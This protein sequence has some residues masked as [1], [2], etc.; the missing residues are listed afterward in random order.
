MVIVGLMRVLIGPCGIETLNH[1][2]IKR[3]PKVLIGPCGIETS[4]RTSCYRET[5][6]LIGPCGIETTNQKQEILAK[7]SINWTLRN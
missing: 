6:V 4:L 5:I 3:L 1:S 7:Q 2:R